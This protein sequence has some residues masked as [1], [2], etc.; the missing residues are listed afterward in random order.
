M[1]TPYTFSIR[2]RLKDRGDGSAN[3][4]GTAWRGAFSTG[5]PP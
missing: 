3:I 5:L 4:V 1:P 2:T